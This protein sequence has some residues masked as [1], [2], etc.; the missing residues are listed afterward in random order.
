[1]GNCLH[2]I[3]AV[4]ILLEQLVVVVVELVQELEV[5]EVEQDWHC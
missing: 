1:M 3:V 2:R 4:E 5:V